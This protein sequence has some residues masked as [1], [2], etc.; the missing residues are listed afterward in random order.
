MGRKPAPKATDELSCT[1]CKG[2]EGLELSDFR[3]HRI[4]VHGATGT[5]T[6]GL[7]MKAMMHLDGDD[8]FAWTYKILDGQKVVGMRYTSQ[9]RRGQDK[10]M[11]AHG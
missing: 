4:D 2:V 3:K 7:T 9:P 6:A 5:G 11:W 10:A 1:L 8:W